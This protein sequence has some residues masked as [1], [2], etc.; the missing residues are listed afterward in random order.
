MKRIA[1]IFAVVLFLLLFLTAQMGA[2][3]SDPKQA[4]FQAALD[5]MDGA[6]SGDS[7]QDLAMV[8]VIS[9]R[10]YDYLQMARIDGHWKIVNVLWV[11]N[12]AALPPQKR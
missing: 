8:K 1:V 7:A 5:Y 11:M 10:Y 9:S 12:P 4:I 2:Q 6:H 3:D